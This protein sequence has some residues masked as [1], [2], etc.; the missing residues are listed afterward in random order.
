MHG[1]D[2]I[3]LRGVP[4]TGFDNLILQAAVKND[5]AFLFGIFFQEG[6][7]RD[8]VFLGQFLNFCHLL[9]LQLLLERLD[10]GHHLLF[11]QAGLLLIQSVPDAEQKQ[12]RVNVQLLLGK[13]IA[14]IQANG[15]A[16][17][18]FLGVQLRFFLGG[19]LLRR[20]SQHSGS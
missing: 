3:G 16:E 14:E 13:V 7:T 2:A 1:D 20:T 4:F 5:H 15:V 6:L 9:F 18:A 11:A 12:V 10:L 8:L 17:T 19:R